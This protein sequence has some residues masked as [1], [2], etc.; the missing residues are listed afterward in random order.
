MSDEATTTT[1]VQAPRALVITGTNTYPSDGRPTAGNFWAELLARLRKLLGDLVVVT[2]TAYIPGPLLAMRRFA[3]QRQILPHQWWD[4]VEVYR[5][6]YLSFRARKGLRLGAWFFH[7][8]AARTCRRLHASRA[9]D[10]V[11]GYEFRYPA[12][13]ARRI[14]RNLGLPCVSWAIGSDVNT[15]PGRSAGN[16]ALL[17]GNV[18]GT[19][20]V[21]TESDALRL[22]ILAKCPQARNVHT[23]YKGIDLGEMRLGAERRPELR[24]K[25]GLAEGSPCMISAGTVVKTKG[26]HE[27]YE[28]FAR[29]SQTQ[30]KLRAIWVGRGPEAEPLRQQ[31]RRDGLADRFQV[32]GHMLRSSVLEY[33]QAAD[34][35]AFP[36]HMEGLPNVVM[37]ALACGLPTV[38]TAVGGTAEVLVH[39]RTGL[40]VPAQD[41]AALADAVGR[42]LAN[43][44]WAHELAV[45][46]SRFVNDYFDV[47]KNAPVALEILQ[48]VVRREPPETPVRACAGVRPG[49]L[50]VEELQK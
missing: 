39:E 10:V 15:S 2:P 29:L 23:F 50:P 43:R 18:R 17:R 14:A 5:P 1:G 13:A 6:P 8:S 16:C 37:E 7:R 31:A 45:R 12:Y 33:M 35:M 47:D 40:L 20:L 34:V 38:A 30:P 49:Y 22:A 32:T 41:P 44:P 27:F 24:A 46:G 26:V 19:D 21:L 4:G 42:M 11:V 28:A 9:F 3:V 25:L 48:R 36:S